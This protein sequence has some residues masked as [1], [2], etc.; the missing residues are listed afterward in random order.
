MS[1]QA[2]AHPAVPE[3]PVR[4]RGGARPFGHEHADD[5]GQRVYAVEGELFF[6]SSND[7]VYQ[8]DYAGD[9]R[10]VVIDM[11]KARIWDASTVATLDAI[12]TK[13]ASKG[14]TVRIVGLNEAS[15][16]RHERL[17]GTLGAGHR[18]QP[19]QRVIAS[20]GVPGPTLHDL[21]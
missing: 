3:A 8:F 10:D 18:A 14:K 13:Y 15:A 9:P 17:A 12:T 4:A 7:L 19:P 21:I 11:T 5:D 2:R 20:C 16:E 6:A 1:T